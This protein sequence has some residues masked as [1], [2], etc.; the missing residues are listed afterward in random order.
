[1]EI[2]HGQYPLNLKIGS[3]YIIIAQSIIDK[4]D[5]LPRS[6]W[7]DRGVKN[8]ETVGEHTEELIKLANKYFPS[9]YGLAK[10][11]KIHDWPESDET[12]GDP[13]TD[14]LCPETKRWTKEDKNEAELI[15]MKKI[16]D[17]LGREGRR[18]FKLWQEYEKRKTP[19]SLIAHQLDNF[20][21]IAQAIRYQKQGQPVIAQ[22]FIDYYGAEIKHPGL[23]DLIEI[24]KS[25]L[26]K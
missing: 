22:E 11:L 15:V 26:I 12:I 16:C 8:P 18:L 1:M 9:L 17:S 3:G 2:K 23:R 6:R 10:M 25:G 13:R 14:P 19:R 5:Q 20:Q 24:A 4:L 21:A 7:V